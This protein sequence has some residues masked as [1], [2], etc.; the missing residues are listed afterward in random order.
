MEGKRLVSH[1]ICMI[2]IARDGDPEC[3]SRITIEG[4]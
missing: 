1:G 2:I 4:L 3:I